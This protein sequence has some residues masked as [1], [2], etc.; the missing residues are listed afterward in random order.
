MFVFKSVEHSAKD[1]NPIVVSSGDLICQVA[2]SLADILFKM[3]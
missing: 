3:V 2:F 1:D